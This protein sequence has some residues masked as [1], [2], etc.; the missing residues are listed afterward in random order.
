[1]SV[2]IEVGTDL[3][4]WPDVFI[5]GADTASST[6]GVT[7]TDNA[8]G[9]DTITLIGSALDEKSFARLRVEIVTP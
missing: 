4:S 6:A 9:T 5:V 3:V 7:V 2:E 1:V 8:D